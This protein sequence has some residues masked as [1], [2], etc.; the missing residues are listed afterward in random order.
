MG[1]GAKAFSQMKKPLQGRINHSVARWC[2]GD[3]SLEAL[4]ETVKRIGFSAIDLV[5]PDEWHILK[6][7]EVHCAMCNGAEINLTDGWND[8]QF[9]D[10]LIENY[11]DI[12]P[13]VAEAG[14][15][16]LI[17]FSGN[18][19]N[20]S[21]EEGLANAVR[22]LKRI[23]PLAEQL[24][25]VI[26][27]ELFKSNVDHPDYMCDNSNWGIALCDALGS[28][29]F[30]LLYDIYH[31]QIS[32]GDIIRTIRE[33]HSY[34][35]HYHTAGVPG[36]HEIN[37]SQELHYPAIMRAIAETGFEGYVAQ[38]FIPTGADP[39]ASLEEGVRL[40]DI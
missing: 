27:M 39:V 31:M 28:E 23:L 38:E 2:F 33:N 40:C 20:L 21:S 34:F 22:G 7:Q 4:C 32:E 12:I 9:H 26:H 19:R 37:E 8:R 16:N 17:C 13:K 11:L 14:Y 35:G 5:G 18:R 3:M 1:A 36:R 30:K 6:K 24:G 10:Q 15:T 29:H 25:V